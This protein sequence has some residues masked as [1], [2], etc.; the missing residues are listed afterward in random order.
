MLPSPRHGDV[1][2]TWS[3]EY[4]AQAD[5]KA[6]EGKHDDEDPRPAQKCQDDGDFGGRR[7]NH[8]QRKLGVLGRIC[9]SPLPCDLGLPC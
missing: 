6:D 9:P 8:P 4:E 5:E 7:E 3:G 1:A 2:R